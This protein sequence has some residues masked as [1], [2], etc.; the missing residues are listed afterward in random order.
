LDAL[1]VEILKPVMHFSCF[2]PPH[3]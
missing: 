1:Q 2:Y 3:D